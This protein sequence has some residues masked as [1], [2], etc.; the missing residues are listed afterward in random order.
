[1][2]R[3]RA[4]QRAGPA[5][6]WRARESLVSVGVRGRGPDSPA[7]RRRRP[8]AR[9]DLARPR[10][11]VRRAAPRMSRPADATV[12]GPSSAAARE[13]PETPE[14]PET[15]TRRKRLRVAAI[16]A[17]LLMLTGLILLLARP[18]LV[19]ARVGPAAARIEPIELVGLAWAVFGCAVWLA[20][21]A[22]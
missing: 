2:A 3:R 9:R 22:A 7:R 14:T 8:G 13:R 18:G 21:K 17:C 20:R 5:A 6:A 4:A 1:A 11:L 16:T 12:P 15:H 19:S 10:P